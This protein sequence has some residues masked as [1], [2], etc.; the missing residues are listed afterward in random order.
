MSRVS[1]LGGTM[2]GDG[3]LIAEFKNASS[4]LAPTICEVY[5]LEDS[6]LY[7]I[8]YPVGSEPKSSEFIRAAAH[9]IATVR[10]ARAR[11]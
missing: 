8:C 6:L 2:Y 5:H 3:E 7:T 1:H 4:D 11:A 9:A 10:A